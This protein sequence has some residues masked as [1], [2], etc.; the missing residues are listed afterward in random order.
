MYALSGVY[1]RPCVKAWEW[2]LASGQSSR[3]P[4]GELRVPP[5]VFVSAGGSRLVFLHLLAMAA[6]LLLTSCG[7]TPIPAKGEA[8]RFGADR[9]VRAGSLARAPATGQYDGTLAPTGE[10][11]GEKLGALV[12]AQGG[13]KA[14]LEAKEKERAAQA[15][16]AR[17]RAEQAQRPSKPVEAPAASPTQQ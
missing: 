2:R 6:A 12:P 17:E 8:Q 15:A 14:Q 10:S 3:Q 1:A 11:R 5:I 9:T 13:Q 7:D 4:F 16:E